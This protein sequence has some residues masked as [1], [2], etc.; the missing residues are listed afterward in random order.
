MTTQL[1]ID[2]GALYLLLGD[3]MAT[4]S[5]DAALQPIHGVLLHTDQLD[6]EHTVL[7]GT[8]TDRY[9][10]SQAHEPI[11]CGC[12]PETFLPL[13]RVLVAALCPAAAEHEDEDEDD[14]WAGPTGDVCLVRDGDTLTLRH[15]GDRA[16]HT[17]RVDVW[18]SAGFPSQHLPR[19][20]ADADR[21]STTEIA[22]WVLP[23]LARIAQRRGAGVAVT[24][25]APN[26]PVQVH[27]GDRYRAVVMPGKAAATPTVPPLFLP[28]SVPRDPQAEQERAS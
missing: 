25:Q 9:I 26:Q 16:V 13:L 11:T 28:P 18:P 14:G 4:A 1:T 21:A 7:V 12:L 3:L 15:H 24:V 23:V 10:L 20:F 22:P 2:A 19:L 5:P 27:I 6:D 17:V 8:S